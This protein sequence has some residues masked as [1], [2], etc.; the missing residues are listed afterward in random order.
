MRTVSSITLED[1][2]AGYGVA[3]ALVRQHLEDWCLTRLDWVQHAPLN[4]PD[5]WAQIVSD[6]TGHLCVLWASGVLQGETRKQSYYVTCDHST[7]I[8]EDI[9][10][11]RVVC[12]IGVAPE[13]PAEFVVFRL[14][15]PLRINSLARPTAERTVA[16]K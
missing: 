9:D 2:T 3:A 10:N 11:G 13:K 7:M 15:I 14:R 1:S 5:L 16:T 8:P 12:D 4:G 6:L